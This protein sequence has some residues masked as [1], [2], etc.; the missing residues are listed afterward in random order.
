VKGG[1]KK[2]VDVGK[3]KEVRNISVFTMQFRMIL[4]GFHTLFAAFD[5]SEFLHLPFDWQDVEA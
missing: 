3:F 2:S 4:T 5:R 1:F